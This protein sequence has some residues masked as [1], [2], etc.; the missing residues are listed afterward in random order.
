MVNTALSFFNPLLAHRR[1]GRR[2][3]WPAALLKKWGKTVDVQISPDFFSGSHETS[4]LLA[5]HEDQKQS[6]QVIK[7]GN[8]GEISPGI[9]GISL[10]SGPCFH[11]VSDSLA[12][13]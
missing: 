10:L 6:P 5:F 12:G 7:Q 1:I 9:M 2:S 13:N 3:T 11:H 8:T 4:Q